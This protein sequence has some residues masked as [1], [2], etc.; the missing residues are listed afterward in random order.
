VHRWFE[1]RQNNSGRRINLGELVE[2]SAMARAGVPVSDQTL[3]RIRARAYEELTADIRAGILEQGGSSRIWHFRREVSSDKLMV[4]Q[5]LR[6]VSR[7]PPT[8]IAAFRCLDGE[9]NRATALGLLLADCWVPAELARGWLDERGI[10]VPSRWKARDTDVATPA[11]GTRVTVVDSLQ[12]ANAQASTAS[13][14]AVGMPR[15][16]SSECSTRSNS[17]IQLGRSPA[18]I[19][20]PPG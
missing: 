16:P 1:D 19:T 14:V 15:G 6:V 5:R 3:G 10:P 17:Q 4:G 11:A 13:T 20:P 12:Q 7:L 8:D 9:S 2:H 18:G